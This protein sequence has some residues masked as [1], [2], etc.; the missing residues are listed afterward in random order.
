MVSM[1][2]HL[3]LVVLLGLLTI[4]NKRP[5]RVAAELVAEP[6]SEPEGV[7]DISP[8]EV[9]TPI[10]TVEPVPP[11]A[12]QTSIATETFDPSVLTTSV[13]VDATAN[14]S[15]LVSGNPVE[16]ML[17]MESLGAGGGLGT[18][19]EFGQ[20]LKRA[21]A[22]GG[23]IQVSLIWFNYNDLDLHVRYMPSSRREEHIFFGARQSRSGGLLDVDMNAG[24][25]RND[26]PVENIFWPKG[27][28]PRGNFEVYVD[29]YSNHGGKDPTKFEVAVY[30]KGKVQTFNG[31][32]RF[33]EPIRKITT[34]SNR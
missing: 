14:N 26:E 29:H 8:I 4:A 30:V 1:I 33:G 13:T 5:P 11:V 3:L 18:F 22:Q 7:Q 21:G 25:D 24:A 2:V 6:S 34:F 28:A 23:D 10:S 32:I 20:R 31:E 12:A 19:G 9:E 17:T 16:G 27:R 15:A